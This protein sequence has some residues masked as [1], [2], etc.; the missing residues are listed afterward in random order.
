MWVTMGTTTAHE[1]GQPL[2]GSRVFTMSFPNDWDID[3]CMTA[4][5]DPKGVPGA[6][7][8]AAWQNHSTGH[9]DWVDSDNPEFAELVASRTGCRVGTP[10]DVEETHH[11]ENGPP[12]IGPDGPTGGRR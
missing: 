5:M 12:G 9:P 3:E 10:A 8:Q 7:G 2:D 1:A 4:L 11:T 6:P